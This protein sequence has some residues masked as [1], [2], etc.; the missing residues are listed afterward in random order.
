MHRARRRTGVCRPHLYTVD[1]RSGLCMPMKHHHIVT[2]WSCRRSADVQQRPL[3]HSEL[4]I[5]CRQG[6][7]TDLPRL[8]QRD[9]HAHSDRWRPTSNYAEI[10]KLHVAFDALPEIIHYWL[11]ALGWSRRALASAAAAASTPNR[12]KWSAVHCTVYA[13]NGRDAWQI[14]QLVLTV[15]L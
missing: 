11:S 6:P 13:Y 14:D 15:S 9:T 7:L 1:S 2:S 10:T 4:V 3:L 12:R 5:V 8:S